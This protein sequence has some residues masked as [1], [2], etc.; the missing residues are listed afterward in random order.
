MLIVDRMLAGFLERPLEAADPVA[1]TALRLGTYQLA[2]TRSRTTPPLAR[3]SPWYANGICAGLVNA[4][5]RRLT[6]LSSAGPDR[7]RR[8]RR[9]RAYGARRPGRSASCATVATADEVE[10]AA[11]ALAAARPAPAARQPVPEP[12]EELAGRRSASAGHEMTPGAFGIPMSCGSSRGP[13]ARLLPDYRE[14]AVHRAGR[15]VRHWSGTHVEARPGERDPGRLRRSRRQDRP[16]RLRRHPRYGRAVAADRR[17]PTR[18]ARCART[19]RRLGAEVSLLAQ[20]ARRPCPAGD[21]RR[22]PGRRARAP[23]SAR[24]GAAPSCS[25]A[26]SAKLGPRRHLPASRRPS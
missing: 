24:R 22:R 6:S 14:R 19:A 15:G 9:L 7:R 13:P 20:D 21:L 8:G 25:G 26:R 18:A 16:P 11:A 17:G 1:R 23:A 10:P 5:L 2:F 12:P 3:R 4:I